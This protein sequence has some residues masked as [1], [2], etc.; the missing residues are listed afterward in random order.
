MKP[1]SKTHR[2]Y[3]RRLP[4]VFSRNAMLSIRV[5]ERVRRTIFALALERGMSASEY[6]ARLFSDHLT[7]VTRS[8]GQLPAIE[9]THR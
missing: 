3:A 9:E 4:A 7:Q 5:H 6:C 8:R 2:H 1:F